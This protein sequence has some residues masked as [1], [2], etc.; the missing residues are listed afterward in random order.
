VR[1]CD[2]AAAIA[3]ALTPGVTLAAP[4]FEGDGGGAFAKTTAARR[5]FLHRFEELTCAGIEREA[6]PPSGAPASPK[7]RRTRLQT[8]ARSPAMTREEFTHDARWGV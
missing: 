3:L 6:R 1:H 4:R 5:P 8:S 2:Y 7:G